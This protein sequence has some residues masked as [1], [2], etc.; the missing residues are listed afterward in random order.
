MT[1]KEYIDLYL[2]LSELEK[3]AEALREQLESKI[4]T[5]IKSTKDNFA[6]GIENFSITQ[7]PEKN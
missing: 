6:V 4:L 1:L 2:K 7:Y 3:D 5:I